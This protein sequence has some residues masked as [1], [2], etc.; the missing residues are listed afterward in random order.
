MATFTQYT[1]KK[2]DNLTKIARQFK[3]TVAALV[4][5]NGIANPNKIRIGATLS[6]PVTESTPVIDSTPVDPI[7]NTNPPATEAIITGNPIMDAAKAAGW[8]Q[9]PKL[10]YLI[11][12]V[13]L[14]Y[15]Y[16]RGK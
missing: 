15:L 7:F 11:A 5:A 6:I 9:P 3:T 8:L 12:G 16:N 2:G 1:V 4:K 10:Y 13:A 14:L